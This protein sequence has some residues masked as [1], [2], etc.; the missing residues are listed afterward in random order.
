MSAP[1]LV[2]LPQLAPLR[3]AWWELDELGEPRKM[4]SLSKPAVMQ[5]AAPEIA[6]DGSRVQMTTDLTNHSSNNS[7]GERETWTSPMG[8]LKALTAAVGVLAEENPE[9]WADDPQDPEE[10]RRVVLDEYHRWQESVR[11]EGEA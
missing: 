9:G 7:T 8:E 3:P 6:N 2:V 10:R 4:V 5:T 1:R 11:L